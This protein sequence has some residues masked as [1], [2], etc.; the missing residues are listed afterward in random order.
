MSVLWDIWSITAENA[1]TIDIDRLPDGDLVHPIYR[2]LRVREHSLD[3][4]RFWHI[5]H[6]LLTGEGERQET[7]LSRAIYGTH[8]INED[9]Y[10]VTP[11][12]AKV[13]ASALADVRRED[14][15]PR[16]RVEDVQGLYYGNRFGDRDGL[17]CCVD[18]LEDLRD[19]YLAMAR[20]DYGGL[21]SL[22]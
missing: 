7:P 6:Y 20:R 12:D 3:I 13:I 11:E 17:A 2:E 4:G 8:N 15:E 16:L 1:R 9:H 5:V 18:A 10:F 21:I 14:F 19:H 22:G